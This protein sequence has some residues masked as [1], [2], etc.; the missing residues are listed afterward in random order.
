MKMD[1]AWHVDG[2]FTT[3][4]RYEHSGSEH[5]FM[6]Y[7]YICHLHQNLQ[8][9]RSAK[10][11]GHILELQHIVFL[12]FT[13]FLGVSSVPP[14]IHRSSRTIIKRN[15]RLALWTHQCHYSN[16]IPPLYYYEIID[17][18][19]K[20]EFDYYHRNFIIFLSA[21]T[22]K[23]CENIPILWHTNAMFSPCLT[24][25]DNTSFNVPETD[26]FHVTSLEHIQQTIREHNKSL[27]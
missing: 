24:T 14:I 12:I 16:A 5:V 1:M 18:R 6:L 25:Y 22:E 11:A 15:K 10:V 27:K 26:P 23:L 8:H 13:L 20:L 7:C 3:N 17:T 2:F 4:I 21:M 19:C 9:S